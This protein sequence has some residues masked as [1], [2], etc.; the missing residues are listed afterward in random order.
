MLRRLTMEHDC[1][2]IKILILNNLDSIKISE[3]SKKELLRKAACDANYL[4][5]E[6]A[7]LAIVGGDF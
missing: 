4:V 6:K 3:S 7:G 5:R 1:V 2:Y